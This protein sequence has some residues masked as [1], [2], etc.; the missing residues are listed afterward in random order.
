QRTEKRLGGVKR[1][2]AVARSLR[3]AQ[4]S[5]AEYWT[6]LTAALSFWF[7]FFRAKKKYYYKKEFFLFLNHATFK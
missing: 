2:S 7:F 1:H 3:A 6:K 4:G 5:P